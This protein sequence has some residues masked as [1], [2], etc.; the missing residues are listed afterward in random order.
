[1]TQTD[2]HTHIPS[3]R[4]PVGAKNSRRHFIFDPLCESGIDKGKIYTNICAVCMSVDY[5]HLV[6]DSSIA[7]DFTY[8]NCQLCR[9]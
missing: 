6:L 9:I 3:P 4:A 5:K 2:T 8:L 7:R 1:M